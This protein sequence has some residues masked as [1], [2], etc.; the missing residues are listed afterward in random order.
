MVS[1]LHRAMLAAVAHDVPFRHWLLSD[2]LPARRAD[3]LAALP[4]AAPTIGDT[5]GRRETH[6]GLRQFIT[7]SACETFPVCA[8]LATSLQRKATTDLLG[9]VCGRSL[10]GTYLRIEYCLDTADF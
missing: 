5:Q 9:A 7:P 1:Q 3:E 6:S 2:V 10:A 4:F 8:T